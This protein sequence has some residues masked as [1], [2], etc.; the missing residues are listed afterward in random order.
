VRPDAKHGR[1]RDKVGQKPLFGVRPGGVSSHRRWASLSWWGS[2]GRSS[3]SPRDQIE[4]PAGAF[5]RRFSELTCVSGSVVP[6]R[7]HHSGGAPVRP[8]RQRREITS[9]NHVG[10]CC[11]VGQ[12]GH[13]KAML[14][15]PLNPAGFSWTCP[16]VGPSS[17]VGCSPRAGARPA[18]ASVADA[19]A[20]SDR[21]R[22]L[23]WARVAFVIPLVVIAL[24]ASA[25]PVSP[26]L[27]STLPHRYMSKLQCNAGGRVLGRS[28]RGSRSLVH[29]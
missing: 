11:R 20:H 29:R 23:P 15:R 10:A 25:R 14:H 28:L 5:A 27:L 8:W 9:R 26:P 21:P 13:A 16:T 2:A 3:A 18:R 17:S 12:C 22:R 24:E 4:F 1:S 19:S 6:D 7:S